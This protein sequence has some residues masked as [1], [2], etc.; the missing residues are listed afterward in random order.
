MLWIGEVTGDVTHHS[1]HTFFP[2]MHF[3]Q[4][5]TST[6]PPALSVGDVISMVGDKVHG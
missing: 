2:G 6:L 4:M 5:L 1:Y 3:R